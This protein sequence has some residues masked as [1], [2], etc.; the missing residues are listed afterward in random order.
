MDSDASDCESGGYGD[1]SEA[2]GRDL[3]GGEG[4]RAYDSVG[5]LISGQH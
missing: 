3:L 2:R 1:Q 4:I 5:H